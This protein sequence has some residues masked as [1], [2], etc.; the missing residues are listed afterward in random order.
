MLL[1]VLRNVLVWLGADDLK[2]EGEFRWNDGTL[3]NMTSPGA[4]WRS[5]N[6]D[7]QNGD[8]HCLELREE[9]LNDFKCYNTAPY[10]VC[11]TSF[12]LSQP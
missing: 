4:P 3:M 12:I 10:T 5:G 11:Q 9:G 2:K 7:N 6:P 1:A 8:D